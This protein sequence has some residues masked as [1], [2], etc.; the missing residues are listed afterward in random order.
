MPNI[1]NSNGESIFSPKHLSNSR[2]EMYE[3]CPMQTFFRYELGWKTP[4]TAMLVRGAAAHAAIEHI[5][6]RQMAGTPIKIDEAFDVFSLAFEQEYDKSEFEIGE[7]EKLP[8]VKEVTY[9]AI[10]DFLIKRAHQIQPE[11][12][13]KSFEIPIEGTEY[14]YAGFIDLVDLASGVPEI[15]DFKTKNAFKKELEHDADVSEQLTSYSFVYKHNTGIVPRVAHE[16]IV[17]KKDTDFIRLNRARDNTQRAV[18]YANVKMI[19]YAIEN[20]IYYRGHK[21]VWHCS[22]KW[23]G[24]FDYCLNERPLPQKI[25]NM[26]IDRLPQDMIELQKMVK[27]LRKDKNDRR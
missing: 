25:R 22:P 17:V 10:S 23:C 13:E 5:L 16:I 24:W 27:E 18:W 1:L 6:K 2:V 21:N 3:R 20:A 14:T 11:S 15:V 9:H 4:S 26:G 12:V 8:K 19:A 7:E